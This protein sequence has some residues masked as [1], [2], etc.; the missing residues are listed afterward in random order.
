MAKRK[1]R[2]FDFE[3]K[4]DMT[5]LIDAVFL[6]IMFFLLTTRIT[7]DL[8]EVDLPVALEAN[9][10]EE[11]GRKE[12][13]VVLNVRL[14]TQAT[15]RGE[16]D[17][18][19]AGKE[20]GKSEL[21]DVLQREVDYDAAPPPHGRGRA[22]EEMGDTKLSQVKVRVRCDRNAKAEYVRTIFEAC[23]EVDPKIYKVEVSAEQPSQPSASEAS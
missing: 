13:T 16:A 5:P 17:I 4:M 19:H 10:E 21:I 18:V 9:P 2:Q 12:S 23:A 3:E 1:A 15:E 22:P 14:K 6:L 20:L 11:K 7:V 8:E